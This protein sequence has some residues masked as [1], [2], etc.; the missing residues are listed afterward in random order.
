MCM[1]AKTNIRVAMLPST[2]ASVLRCLARR[3]MSDSGIA[4]RLRFGIEVGCNETLDSAIDA[5]D[6]MVGNKTRKAGQPYNTM[7]V[8]VS[9]RTR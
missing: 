4:E 5:Y 3:G 9:F 6:D 7:T 8:N 1:Q 2:A